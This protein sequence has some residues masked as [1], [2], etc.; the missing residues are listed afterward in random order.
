MLVAA[1]A[2]PVDGVWFELTSAGLKGCIRYNSGT[3][4]KITLMADV[5]SFPLNTNAK[6]TMVVGE[7]EIEY[8][9][10]DVLYGEL[11]MPN[12]QGQPFMTSALPIFIQ[13]YN[14]GTV[15]SSPNMI[16]KV[17]KW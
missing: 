10:D 12:A 16:V 17:F 15:G 5:S 7:R 9:I 13:K 3:V 8:W 1:A 6:Y 14:S 4:A 11:D 2:E